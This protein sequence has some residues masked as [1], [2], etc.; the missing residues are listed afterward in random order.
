MNILKRIFGVGCEFSDK[1]ELYRNNS[2][3]CNKSPLRDDGSSYC[4]KHR[5]LSNK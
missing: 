3:A 1:C 2:Y 5:E 4:G